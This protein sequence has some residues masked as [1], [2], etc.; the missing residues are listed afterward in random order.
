MTDHKRSESKQPGVVITGVG[1]ASVGE[2]LGLLEGDRI[3]AINGR[4]VRDLLDVQFYGAAAELHLVVERADGDEWELSVTKDAGVGLGLELQPMEIQ[5]CNNNCVFCFVYQNPRGQR[6]SLYVKDEDYRFSFL[7]GHYITLSNLTDEEYQRII[8]QRLSPLYV[9]VHA[10]DPDLRA[11]LL[12]GKRMAPVVPQLRRLI[13]G[14]ITLH[15]QIVLCPGINDGIHLTQTIQDLAALHPGV[16]SVAVVPVGLTDHREGLPVLQ[17]VDEAYAQRFLGELESVQRE[18]LSVLGTRFVFAA[19]EW[20]V[21]AGRAI[22][23]AAEYEG[24]PQ[25]ADGVGAMALFREEL[26]LALP[27]RQP[28]KGRF[29]FLTGKLFGP[30]LEKHVAAVEKAFVGW[31]GR[32]VSLENRF[33]GAG[34]TVA[35]LLSGDDVRRGLAQCRPG[36]IPV[37]PD[38]ML[39]EDG[40]TFLDSVTVVQLRRDVHPGLTV[41]AASAEGLL[42]GGD[43]RSLCHTSHCSL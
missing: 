30:T 20:F 16:R 36:E 31:H 43:D 26:A 13:R 22:P 8:E 37:I 33:L 32:V 4:P 15:T 10:T 11:D 1:P 12:R 41:V 27:H 5:T 17:R 38:V 34:I 18:N 2:R 7:H 23:A 35:G 42:S 6:R 39:A 19:D 25:I 29:C 14:G 40:N 24:Y 28:S 21:L 3:V 9:S